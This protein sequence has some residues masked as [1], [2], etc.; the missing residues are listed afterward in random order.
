[1]EIKENI[2]SILA[3]IPA[4]VRLIAV[5]K[6]LSDDIVLQA[7]KA[8]QRMFG[9]N[10]AQDLK[11]RFDTLPADIQWH[12]IGHLQTNKVKFILHQ[13][14]MIHSVDSFKL[15]QE[16]NKEASRY[17]RKIKCLLQFHIAEEETKFGL[18]IDEAISLLEEHLTSNLKNVCI[19]GVMGMASFTDD[20]VQVRKEFRI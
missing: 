10:R 5:S 12:F 14:E 18:D 20:D 19:S 13:V 9:E 7:Y 8:G 4:H 3:E 6:T 15:L 1:M 11:K 16:I 17:Q 2:N